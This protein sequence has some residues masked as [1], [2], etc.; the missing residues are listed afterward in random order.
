MLNEGL[1]KTKRFSQNSSLNDI[2]SYSIIELRSHLESQFE[3]WMTWDNW[4]S[5]NANTWNDNDSNTWVW[6]IDHIIP[7][8]KFEYCFVHD[9]EFKKMLGFK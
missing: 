2:L 7:Q 8:S 9:T 3:P 4:G 6:N 5:Y 1:S